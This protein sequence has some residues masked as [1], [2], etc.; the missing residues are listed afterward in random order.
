[1][2]RY[3]RSSDWIFTSSERGSWHWIFKLEPHHQFI[4]LNTSSIYNLHLITSKPCTEDIT[5]TTTD[6][7]TMPTSVDL[8]CPKCKKTSI[9]I[10][11]MTLLGIR[12]KHCNHCCSC[13]ITPMVEVDSNNEHE[14]PLK[15]PR[16]TLDL[17]HDFPKF[18]TTDSLIRTQASGSGAWFTGDEE[19]TWSGSDGYLERQERAWESD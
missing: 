11:N 10:I 7:A 19:D 9:Y 6:K 16:N 14:P 2:F 17:R 5:K 12:C 4:L 8:E 1:V 18:S 3:I 13:Y 15:V